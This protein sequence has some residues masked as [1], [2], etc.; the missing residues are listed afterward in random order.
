MEGYSV[1]VVL[2]FFVFGPPLT[3]SPSIDGHRFARIYLDFPSF[4]CRLITWSIA[5]SRG[6]FVGELW[7]RWGGVGKLTAKGV[8]ALRE[9]GRY[10]D[11]DGLHLR[12]D[13]A[14]RRYW[15][16]RVQLDGRR[17]DYSLGREGPLLRLGDAREAAL[18]LRMRLVGGAPEVRA[19]LAAVR[20]PTFKEAAL[21]VHAAGSRAWKSSV[22]GGQ[23][24]RTLEQL[25]F[26]LIGDLRVNRI[27]RR[28]LYQALAPIWLTTPETARRVLQRVDRVL[29]YAVGQGWME[30]AIDIRLVREALPRQTDRVQHMPALPASEV[31]EFY[32]RL[33]ASATTPAVRLALRFLMLTAQRPG[34]IAAARWADIEGDTWTIPA[35]ELKV[36]ANGAHRVPLSTVAQDVLAMA[37]QLPGKTLLFSPNHEPLS[38]DTLRMAMRRMGESATPH[39]F[40]SS[41]KEWSLTAGWPDYLSERQLAHADKDKV[42][43]AYARSDLLEERRPMLEAWGQFISGSAST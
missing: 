19:A 30:A 18:R 8:A 27:G 20:A 43:A 36:A 1:G 29:R 9:P 22:H 33:D 26:P 12:I 39:G 5:D 17:R 4:S 28:D 7:E 3:V 41:F 31:P 14:G 15:V 21:E 37:R 34:N 25:I 16:V 42:R 35:A 38:R 32:R 23:W 2:R 13:S 6:L 10:G 40:R 24:L 11:G